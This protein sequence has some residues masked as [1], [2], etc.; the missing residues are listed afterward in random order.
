MRSPS[1]SDTGLKETIVKSTASVSKRNL[2]SRR[3][4]TPLEGGMQAEGRRGSLNLR[5]RGLPVP[6]LV[7]GASKDGIWAVNQQMA[8]IRFYGA[9]AEL[10]SG[11][12]PV[13]NAMVH[14]EVKDSVHHGPVD[15]FNAAPKDDC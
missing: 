7:S 1:V 10:W 13:N 9:A 14:T 12:G 8:D 5:S 15:A 2:D 4:P 11:S 3:Q 6:F